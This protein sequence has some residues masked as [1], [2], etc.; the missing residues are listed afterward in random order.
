MNKI[1]K[2]IN[3]L[4]DKGSR[5]FK[6]DLHYFAK[7][8]F[9]LTSKQI[10]SIIFGFL[11]SL[12]YAR[13]L[14]KLVFGQYSF[15]FAIVAFF[16]GFANPGLGTAITR[17]VAQKRDIILKYAPNKTFIWAFISVL[18]FW[19]LGFYYFLKNPA[20]FTLGWI[21]ILC[22]L[23]FIP[24]WSF[25][26][27]DSFLI[28][29]KNFRLLFIFNLIVSG[30]NFIFMGL[31]AIFF[32]QTLLL[33]IVNL[34]LFLFINISLHYYLVSKIPK[35]NIAIKK[36][37]LTF[38]KKLT[39]IRIINTVVVF[40]DKIIIG[41]FLGFEAVAIYTFAQL[42]PEQIKAFLKNFYVLSL[43]KFSQSKNIYNKKGLITKLVQFM[44]LSLSMALV[45]I[46]LAPLIFPFFFPKYHEA[47]IFSQVL[48]LSLI[49]LPMI[50][51]VALLEAK[52]DTTGLRW[53]Y[54][55]T[56]FVQLFLLFILTIKFGLWG[57]V[58]AIIIGRILSLLVSLVILK[59]R[60]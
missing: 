9:W 21:F 40:A 36:S 4:L 27:W 30:L 31:T 34:C 18:P 43:P 16:E 35:K 54:Y 14:S 26:F 32:A 51:I 50:I 41:K 49:S 44:L 10:I 46:F 55:P 33:I 12:I 37:D 17:A 42:F 58:W 5:V 25:R 6:L 8:S 56:Y 59:K 2:K 38:S 23:F 52:T 3:I 39:D 15:V 48:S 7:G 53:L 1:E 60:F 22:G 24:I 45:Y 28:G 57:V 11:L 47:I 19:S 29:Q 13:F 20:D